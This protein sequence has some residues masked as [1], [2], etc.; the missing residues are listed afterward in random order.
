MIAV[1]KT[2]P[3]SDVRL[4][5]ELGITDVGENKDQEAGPKWDEY[6]G[7]PDARRLTWHFVGQLQSN[8]AR[9]VVRYADVVQSVDRLRLVT[10]LENA[11]RQQERTVDCLLQV[12]LD[13]TDADEP[14]TVAARGGVDPDEVS[15]LANR[16]AESDLLRLRGVMAVAPLGADPRPAFERLRRVSERVRAE[17]PEA[18]WISA[19]MSADLEAAIEFGATHVRVGRGILGERGPRR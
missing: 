15:I 18:S 7:Y 19:G 9:S 16:V 4:L 6:L 5:A 8:K 2:A 11:C 10:A 17:H 12:R 14:G 1:T 3:A 13:P